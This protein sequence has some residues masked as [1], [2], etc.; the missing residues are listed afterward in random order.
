VIGSGL[1]TAYEA[2][3]GH[4]RCRRLSGK[5][6]R[7]VAEPWP[8]STELVRTLRLPSSFSLTVAVDVDEAVRM[9]AV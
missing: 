2:D 9:A 5:V 3:A 1:S 4:S 8:I 7:P 6:A